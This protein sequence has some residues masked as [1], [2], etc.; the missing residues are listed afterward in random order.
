MMRREQTCGNQDG[1][2][3]KKRER[4]W[5]SDSVNPGLGSLPLIPLFPLIKTAELPLIS[6]LSLSISSFLPSLSPPPPAPNPLL[7]SFLFFFPHFFLSQGSHRPASGKSRLSQKGYSFSFFFSFFIAFTCLQLF[8][9]FVPL[10][11]PFLREHHQCDDPR[12]MTGHG[13]CC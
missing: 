9:S 3:R 7:Q 10:F 6:S 12:A 2:R 1:E 13:G 5:L 11:F 8:P 4:V